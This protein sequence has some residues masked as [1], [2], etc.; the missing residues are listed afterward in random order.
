MPQ[1]ELYE[2]LLPPNMSNLK[3]PHTLA[4]AFSSNKGQMDVSFGLVKIN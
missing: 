3:L 2:N 1:R 4:F